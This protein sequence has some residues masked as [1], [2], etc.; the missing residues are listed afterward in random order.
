MSGDTQISVNQSPFDLVIFSNSDNGRYYD[1]AYDAAMN[2]V[3][4]FRSVIRADMTDR[5]AVAWRKLLERVRADWVFRINADIVLRQDATTKLMPHL[6]NEHVG[7]L[8]CGV[9]NPLLGEAFINRVGTPDAF[10][11]RTAA[12][13]SAVENFFGVPAFDMTSLMQLAKFVTAKLHNRTRDVRQSIPG[14]IG[15]DRVTPI[16]IGANIS[17]WTPDYT[18][19]WCYRLGAH[20]RGTGTTDIGALLDSMVAQKYDNWQLGIAAFVQGF[21]SGAGPE[22]MVQSGTF[23][24]LLERAKSL[25]GHGEPQRKTR[26]LLI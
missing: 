5:L 11:F 7:A 3:L 21:L 13:H 20:L 1:A 18:F 19:R 17:D 2:Q 8:R 10:V 4:P 12:L 14:T 24:S 6:T 26:T 16:I 9:T 25:A 15:E 23:E 22:I